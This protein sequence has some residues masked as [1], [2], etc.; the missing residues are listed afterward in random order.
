MGKDMASP[1]FDHSEFI[2]CIVKYYGTDTTGG[3]TYDTCFLCPQGL[4][5][6]SA[7]KTLLKEAADLQHE[8]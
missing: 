6:F 2:D 8:V 7:M 4:G 3:S 5:I 1:L